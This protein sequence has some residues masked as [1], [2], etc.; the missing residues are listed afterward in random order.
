MQDDCGWV[1]TVTENHSS[2]MNPGEIETKIEIEKGSLVS[3][4]IL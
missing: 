1:L 3:R 2:Q 4:S